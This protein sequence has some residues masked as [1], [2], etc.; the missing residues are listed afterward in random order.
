MVGEQGTGIQARMSPRAT[1]LFL[2]RHGEVDSAWQGRIYG[3]LDVPL[4]ERGREDGLRVAGALRETDLRA[5]VS[6]RTEHMAACLRARR[7]LS[8]IDDPALRELERGE[9]AGRTPSEV[10]ARWP[11]AWAA[12]F[13]NPGTARPPGGESLNDLLLRVLPRVNHWCGAH[14]G[15]SIALITH[16]WVRVLV[17]RVID[18]PFD[19]APHLDVRTGDVT[20]IRWP[21]DDESGP[22]LEAFAVDDAQLSE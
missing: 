7:G 5:V 12:W 17:C 13:E 18:A 8:R 15:A 14:P 19:R 22:E 21:N 2:I 10:E 3:A 9:W 1:R 4:S 6:A 11:G 16:G 20:L